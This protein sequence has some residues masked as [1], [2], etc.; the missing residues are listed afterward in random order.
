MFKFKIIF[1]QYQRA[2]KHAPSSKSILINN[3]VPTDA[4][5]FGIA[6]PTL[7]QVDQGQTPKVHTIMA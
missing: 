6:G 5:I 7:L 2:P 4:F 1:D 3:C